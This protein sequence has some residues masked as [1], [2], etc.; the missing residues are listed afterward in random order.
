MNANA[1]KFITDPEETNRISQ[2][3]VATELNGEGKK[4]IDLQN[5]IFIEMRNELGIV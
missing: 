5:Q 1:I 3:Y 4:L 2:E